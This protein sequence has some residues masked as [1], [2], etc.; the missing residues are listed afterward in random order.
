MI[1]TAEVAALVEAAPEEVA[2]MFD[3]GEIDALVAAAP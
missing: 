1:S 2:G 3:L